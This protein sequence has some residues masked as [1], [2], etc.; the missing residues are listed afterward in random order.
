MDIIKREAIKTSSSQALQTYLTALK[1]IK[2]QPVTHRKYGKGSIYEIYI[3]KEYP[4]P[5]KVKVKVL[6]DNGF[7]SSQFD[8]L[9]CVSSCLFSFPDMES[10]NK[11]IE[12]ALEMFNSNATVRNL[13]SKDISVIEKLVQNKEQLRINLEKF[14]M[15]LSPV[16]RYNQDVYNMLIERGVKNLVHFTKLQNLESILKHGIIPVQGLK[17]FEIDYSPSD[18]DRWDGMEDG[19]SFSVSYPNYRTFF[20]KWK[21]TDEPYVVLIIGIEAIKTIKPDNIAYFPSNAASSLYSRS[22][23]QYRGLDAA[24]LMFAPNNRFTRAQQNIPDSFPTD[25]QAE[26][27]IKGKI[28]TSYIKEIHLN[29]NEYEVSYD[30]SE[31]YKTIQTILSRFD[32]QCECKKSNTYFRP[33]IDYERWLKEP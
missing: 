31:T 10:V 14:D 2:T 32:L 18:L 22:F 13:A 23:E 21:N 29:S 19:I 6:F 5:P 7:K 15:E 33:R 12:L 27:F 1:S 24:Q 9:D 17:Y 26:V 4:C 28:H 16:Q 30:V 3:S 25:P 20:R 11:N 8:I